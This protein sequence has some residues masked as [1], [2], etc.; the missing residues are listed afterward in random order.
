VKKI[1]FSPQAPAAIGP[2]SQ[3]VVHQGL[4]YLSGQIP[5]EPASGEIVVGGI[6]EQAHRVLDNIG[7]V[8]DAAGSGFDKVL[9]VTIYMRDLSQFPEVNDIYRRY[10]PE[11]PPARSTVEAA[12]L[13]KDVLVEMDA[14]AF[15]E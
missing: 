11:N 6:A 2:Y 3:A 5:L 1:I 9:R 4:V 15:V 14:I 12:R 13:P 8:L 10:F 7:A